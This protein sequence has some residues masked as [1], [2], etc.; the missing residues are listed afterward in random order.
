ML[1]SHAGLLWNPLC[2]MLLTSYMRAAFSSIWL[3][4]PPGEVYKN[5]FVSTFIQTFIQCFLYLIWAKTVHDQEEIAVV[6]CFYARP[7]S[8]RYPDEMSKRPRDF[9]KNRKQVVLISADGEQTAV[10]SKALC[11]SPNLLAN[12]L[13]QVPQTVVN[14][15][16]F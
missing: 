11:I 10:P 4:R 5:P 2:Q 12:K 7:L 1:A 13:W 15:V 14:T 16:T 8:Q 3:A 6:I 9:N